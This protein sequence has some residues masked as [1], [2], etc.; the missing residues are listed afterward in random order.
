MRACG[1]RSSVGTRPVSIAYDLSLTHH[2]R[3]RP[4]VKT[5]ASGTIEDAAQP[6]ARSI[7]HDLA[8]GIVS[9]AVG[10]ALSMIVDRPSPRLQ[11]GGVT[12]GRCCPHGPMFGDVRESEDQE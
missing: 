12:R 4:G 7:R 2:H 10:A 5:A 1:V 8:A 11:D 9:H 6:G 3:H